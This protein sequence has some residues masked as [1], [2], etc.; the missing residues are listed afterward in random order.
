MKSDKFFENCKVEIE[1][2][3]KK[4]KLFKALGKAIEPITGVD[5]TEFFSDNI[6]PCIS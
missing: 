2:I 4:L 3:V 1:E 6:A 5:I